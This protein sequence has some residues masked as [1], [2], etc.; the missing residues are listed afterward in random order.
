[1][2]LTTRCCHGTG[3]RWDFYKS[4]FVRCECSALF[5]EAHECIRAIEDGAR[6][7]SEVSA[8]PN[9]PPPS[10]DEATD[11]HASEHAE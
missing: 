4:D 10:P 11:A 7:A 8:I 3:K 5:D 2:S 1:M 9:A 6:S